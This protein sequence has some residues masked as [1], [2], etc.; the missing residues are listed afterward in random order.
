MPWKTG[1]A[2]RTDGA[3]PRRRSS[4]RTK[5]RDELAIGEPWTSLAGDASVASVV[6]IASSKLSCEAFVDRPATEDQHV[7]ARLQSVCDLP[8]ESVQVLEAVRL[9]GGL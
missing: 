5:S 1:P 4:E 8:H 3:P 7:V 2:V 6:R 9:A